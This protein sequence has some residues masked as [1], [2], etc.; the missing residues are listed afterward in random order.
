MVVVK[1]YL[2]TESANLDRSLLASEGVD[3]F[4]ADENLAN[5]DPPVVFASG[6]VRLMVADEE[7]PR[8]REILDAA[9]REEPVFLDFP[10]P[11]EDD[12][13]G[14]GDSGG[15][16]GA[17]WRFDN[18]VM[19]AACVLLGAV[20][21]SALY[22]SWLSG[23]GAHA[24]VTEID[25]DADG[26]VDWRHHYEQGGLRRVT[27][28]RDGDGTVD[29]RIEYEPSVPGLALNGEADQDFDG[30]FE[31]TLVY[32]NGRL[33][34]EVIDEDG[35]GTV[36]AALVLEHEVPVRLEE[37]EADGSTVRRTIRFDPHGRPIDGSA[38]GPPETGPTPEPGRAR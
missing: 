33:V 5:A 12:V 10:E 1:T 14:R 2:N 34:R 15:E 32:E 36:D 4:V 21:G 20:V 38:G 8:A 6:G 28:D 25:P 11:L 19:A 35:D 3:A 13:A 37:F 31:T 29:M 22:R 9:A 24:A 7:L 26:V 17:R 27:G 30:R 18:L 16:E 23:G